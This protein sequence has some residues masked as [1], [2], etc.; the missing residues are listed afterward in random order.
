MVVDFED[1]RFG[2]VVERVHVVDFQGRA[3]LFIF[4]ES[5]L[6][7]FADAQVLISL[8]HFLFLQ[9][10]VSLLDLSFLNWC[11]TIL[12]RLNFSRGFAFNN[13][14]ANGLIFKVAHHVG[15]SLTAGITAVMGILV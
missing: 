5:T 10:V 8:L 7:L 15:W 14:F 12:S 9:R 6:K 11:N 2:F 1:L 4:V 3:Q 13:W